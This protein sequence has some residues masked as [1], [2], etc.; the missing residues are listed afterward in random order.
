MAAVKAWVRT[1]AAAVAT[2]TPTPTVPYRLVT[3]LDGRFALRNRT[4]IVHGQLPA[5]SESTSR[6]SSAV[7]GEL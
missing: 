6:S 2:A 7:A 3:I 1:P 5:G 4:A